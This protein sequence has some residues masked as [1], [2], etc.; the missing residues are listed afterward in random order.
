MKN[1]SVRKVL[2]RREPSIDLRFTSV[3]YMNCLFLFFAFCLI[4]SHDLNLRLKPYVMRYA[5]WYHLHNLK[6][7]KNTH[8]GVY[9]CLILLSRGHDSDN[10]PF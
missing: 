7:V 8:G 10:Q 1:K 2:N 4:Y 9:M 5:I 3:Y 6:N